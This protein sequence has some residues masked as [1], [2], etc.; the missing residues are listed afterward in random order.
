VSVWDGL[1]NPRGLIWTGLLKYFSIH[2]FLILW[3]S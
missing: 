3:S 2:E 1:H